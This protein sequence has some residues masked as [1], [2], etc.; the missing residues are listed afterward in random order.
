VEVA[1]LENFL[2][3]QH[4]AG[5]YAKLACSTFRRK[6]ALLDREAWYLRPDDDQ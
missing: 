5:K 4:L 1:Q 6:K 3:G 2:E